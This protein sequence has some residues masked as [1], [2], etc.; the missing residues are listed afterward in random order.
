MRAEVRQAAFLVKARNRKR[1]C[2]QLPSLWVFADAARFADPSTTLALL[3]PGLCG[4][5][6]RPPMA[7]EFA[8]KLA[9][10]ARA[11]RI[12]TVS[13][14]IKLPGYLQIGTHLRLGRGEGR[15]AQKF[16]TASAH[17]ALELRR[18]RRIGVSLVFLSPL[19]ATLSHPGATP[20][21][22]RRWTALARAARLPVAALGGIA[23]AKNLPRLAAG[24]GAIGAFLPRPPPHASPASAEGATN[25]ATHAK[26]L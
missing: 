11:R 26:S 18:A 10:A 7:P 24:L 16:T 13:A 25:G 19:F 8:E 6:L 3:P 5:V 23:S 20:L 17:N 14:G 1:G 4:L 22:P 9:R 12:K 15:P 2:G 21:G